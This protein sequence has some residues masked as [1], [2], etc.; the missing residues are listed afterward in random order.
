MHSS[1]AFQDERARYPDTATVDDFDPCLLVYKISIEQ[2]VY[3]QLRIFQ[4]PKMQYVTGLDLGQYIL[5]A[6]ATLGGRPVDILIGHFDVACLAVYAAAN[7]QPCH[8]HDAGS[9]TYFWALIWNLTPSSLLSSSTYSY[10]PAGQNRF[11]MPLYLGH[12]F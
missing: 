5:G 9:S 1:V 4:R 2:Q 8:A 12:S 10:T 7:C 3:Q 6:L 11:S